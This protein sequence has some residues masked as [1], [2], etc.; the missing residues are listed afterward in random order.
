MLKNIP[1]NENARNTSVAYSFVW[2]PPSFVK[3]VTLDE[4]QT[5]Y[6]FAQSIAAMSNQSA[7]SLSMT[8][9]IT[10]T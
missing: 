3:F 7:G 10:Y 8:P 4:R 1:L 9:N 6:Y 2:T 5:F